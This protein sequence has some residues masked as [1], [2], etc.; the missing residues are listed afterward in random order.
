MPEGI[1]VMNYRD[2]GGIAIKAQYPEEKIKLHESAQMHILNIHEFSKESG[3]SSLTVDDL[4]ITTYYSGE[5]TNYFIVVKLDSLED[6]DDFEENLKVISQTILDNLEDNKYK[7]LL[8][9][10]FKKISRT[11]E[12]I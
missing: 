11:S 3:I 4:N 5:D 1:F 2:K 7:E 10:L 8:P 6:L 9:S 12:T